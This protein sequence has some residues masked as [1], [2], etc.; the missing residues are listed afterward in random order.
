MQDD[1]LNITIQG[2]DGRDPEDGN[3]RGNSTTPS[4]YI[5]IYHFRTILRDMKN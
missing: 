5:Y 1:T 4:G 3:D 2:H